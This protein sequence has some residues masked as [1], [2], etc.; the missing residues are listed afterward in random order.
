MMPARRYRPLAIAVAAVLPLLFIAALRAR[1]AAMP[2]F[3]QAC[4]VG[5]PYFV[6]ASYRAQASQNQ[7]PRISS[8]SVVL[9]QD[10]PQDRVH[11]RLADYRETGAVWG[12]AHSQAERVVYAAAYHKRSLPYGPGGAGGIYRIDLRTGAV[13][14]FATVPDA[15]SLRHGNL[16][17]GTRDHDKAGARNVGK[18]ALGGMDLS[19]DE[20][21]LYVMNL[22]NRKIY[23]Y[24]IPDGALIGSF[25][26]GATGVPWNRD[27]RP[28]ALT[29]HDGH[30]Y[31]G[32]I[33]AGGTGASLVSKIYRSNPDGTDM[34]EVGSLP[35]GYQRDQGTRWTN[36]SDAPENFTRGR[37]THSPQPMFTDIAFSDDGTL[38]AGFRDRFWDIT[39]QWLVEVFETPTL[40]VHPQFTPTPVVV[41]LAEEGI[42]FGDVLKGDPSGETFAFQTAPEHFDDENALRQSE[43][44]LGGLACIAGSNVV[45]AT[46]Y[47]VNKAP[48][49]RIV[50]E[51]GLYWFDVTTGQKTGHEAVGQPGSFQE[52]APL[53]QSADAHTLYPVIYLFEYYRDVASLGDVET[54]CQQCSSTVPTVTPEP[55]TETSVPATFTPIP[56][57]TPDLPTETP[58]VGPIYLP[59]NLKELC[60]PDRVLVDALLVLD[61]SSSMEGEQIVAAKGAAIAFIEVMDLPDDQVGIVAFAESSRVVS[62]LTG[63]EAALRAAIA[64]MTLSRGTRID[65]GLEE[66]QNLFRATTAR[67][68]ASRVLVLLTD[69]LQSTDPARPIALSESLRT[70]GVDVFVVG[71]GTDVDAA[72]LAALVGAPDRLHMSPGPGDLEAVYRDIANL[73]P[74][75]PDS[76]WGG[77]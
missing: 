54:I 45:A 73:I 4:A 53:V 15:G 51:E 37:G 28:F 34:K 26:H 32:V 29:F 14:L 66:A 65:R 9:F 69:G 72:Y 70:E 12:L 59:I 21:E 42:G 2:D 43:S 63:N 13:T 74:C 60:V 40:E 77:R 23:R 11:F 31:H 36:W 16:S 61:T 71:L 7:P 49:D 52:Y 22:E 30:L 68:G 8:P 27:A 58:T 48:S 1:G 75:P 46:A 3:D 38:V 39:V 35:M 6:A 5:Q 20:S 17:D 10:T 18:T 47:G 67:P 55:P 56:T 24:S 64:A 25:S 76:F 41:L 19:D 62:P 57:V 33:N 44:A 50:G